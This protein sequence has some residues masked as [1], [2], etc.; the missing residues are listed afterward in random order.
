MEKS[1]KEKNTNTKNQPVAERSAAENFSHRLQERMDFANVS[2]NALASELY[3]SHSTVS[4]YRNGKRTP[5]LEKLSSI[6]QIL[7]TSV[8]YLVGNTDFPYPA[9]YP[10]TNKL[11]F[12]ERQLIS[13]YRSLPREKK[14]A[15]IDLVY[16]MRKDSS[17]R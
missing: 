17:T 7:N 4:G 16:A 6:A 13:A 3:V 1:T 14:T 12:E 10:D 2:P 9:E 5:D 11:S 15:I 8:D